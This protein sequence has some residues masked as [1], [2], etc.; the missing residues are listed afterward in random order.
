MRRTPRTVHGSDDA[1]WSSAASTSAPGRSICAILFGLCRL[2]GQR[3]SPAL[4]RGSTQPRGGC[5]SPSVYRQP[6]VRGDRKQSCGSTCRASANPRQIVLPVDRETG[7]PRGFAFVDYADR[8]VAEAAIRRFDQQP[9]KG[10]PLAVSEARPREER[11]AA[12]RVLAA[13]ARRGPARAR[14]A[15]P[16][17]SRRARV[18]GRLARLM[19]AAARRGPAQPQLRAGR[20]AEEQAQAAA[21]GLAIAV[22]RARSKSAGQP[23]LRERRG[24][25]QRESPTTRNRRHRD[26]RQSRHGRRSRRRVASARE[27]RSCRRM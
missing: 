25:A 1:R 4:L 19:A 27:G 14:P 9:F 24:L 12:L 22:R 13:T 8:A 20:A 15:A 5:V 21:Q 2:R 11:P 23:P 6:A 16:A 26:E 10:R 18:A 17:A 3:G 7:R